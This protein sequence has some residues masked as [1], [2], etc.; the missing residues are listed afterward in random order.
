V[1]VHTE[2][3]LETEICDHL[4]KHGWLYNDA[5]AARDDADGTK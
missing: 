2:V 1:S 5:D 4:A 3:H